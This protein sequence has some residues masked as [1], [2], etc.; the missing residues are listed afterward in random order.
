M[1]YK[2]FHIRHI[3]FINRQIENYEGLKI[4]YGKDIVVGSYTSASF[5]EFRDIH[6]NNN[7][8]NNNG[9]LAQCEQVRDEDG[10]TNL[11]L[12]ISSSSAISSMQR[13][14]HSSKAPN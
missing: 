14:R 3:L 13:S 9:E 8:N 10:D 1:L 4:I 6:E 12:P 11:A 7:N 2:G 5:L